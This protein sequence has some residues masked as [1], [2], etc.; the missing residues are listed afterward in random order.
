MTTCVFTIFL[1]TWTALHLNKPAQEDTDFTLCL[2]KFR[3]L[4]QGIIRPEFVLYFA[5]SQRYEAKKSVIAFRRLGYDSWTLTHAFYANMDGFVLHPRHSKSFSITARQL[6]YVVRNNFVEYPSLKRKAI[7]DRSKADWFVKGITCLQI[8]WLVLQLSARL[9]QKLQITTLEHTKM[10]HVI[11]AIGCYTQCA[12]K[13]WDI[14][15]ATHISSQYTLSEMLAP[16]TIP[17][18]RQLNPFDFFDNGSPSW[19]FNV[20]PYLGFR[21]QKHSFSARWFATDRFPMIGCGREAVG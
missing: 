13:P 10:T 3:W 18:S 11:C 21:F 19:S 4:I 2:R 20:Q 17:L 16:R 8:C 7:Q 6:L 5:V 15:T 14:G 12:H 9:A 1:Y